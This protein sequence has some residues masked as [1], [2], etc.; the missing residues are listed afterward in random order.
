MVCT[1]SDAGLPRLQRWSADDSVQNDLHEHV[2]CVGEQWLLW[3][4]LAMFRPVCRHIQLPSVKHGNVLAGAA[5]Y[6]RVR[7][8]AATQVIT[9]AADNSVTSRSVA[10]MKYVRSYANAVVLPDGSVFVVGGQPFPVPFTDDEAVLVGELWDPETEQWSSTAPMG[11]PRTYHSVAVM[12]SDGRVFTGGGGLCTGLRNPC[13]PVV[14]TLAL[15]I[16]C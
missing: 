4:A 9:I 10:D 3:L 16:A 7:G 14:C 11:A 13:A 15:I 12:L 5:D 2:A 8:K 6:D 1:F